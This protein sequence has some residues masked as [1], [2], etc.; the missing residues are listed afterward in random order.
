MVKQ[1]N[2]VYKIL[3]LDL[4]AT[5]PE[6]Q[7]RT[8]GLNLHS[9]ITGS[10]GVILSEAGLCVGFVWVDRLQIDLRLNKVKPKYLLFY[11]SFGLQVSDN[12][13]MHQDLNH[14]E[15]QITLYCTC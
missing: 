9:G 8:G 3:E 15:A 2:F 12:Q 13:L 14:T 11:L 7:D 1:F 4:L 10:G 5:D 6:C